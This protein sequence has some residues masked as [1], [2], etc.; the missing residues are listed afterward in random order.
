MIW[1]G[2]S[3]DPL[4]TFF[5][6]IYLYCRRSTMI[7]LKSI[8]HKQVNSQT[9]K[10][11]CLRQCFR[12]YYH[13]TIGHGYFIMHSDAFVHNKSLPLAIYMQERV[14]V[15]TL[16]ISYAQRFWHISNIMAILATKLNTVVGYLEINFRLFIKQSLNCGCFVC[17]VRH[18]GHTEHYMRHYLWFNPVVLFSA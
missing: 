17:F 10:L 8:S 16:H 2:I 7:Q 6:E 18:W 14:G 9:N 5:F 12:F 1:Y 13:I 15:R 11:L 4:H 3:R